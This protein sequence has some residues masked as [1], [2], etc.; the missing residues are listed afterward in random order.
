MLVWGGNYPMRVDVGRQI[1][2]TA[3][4]GTMLSPS[5]FSV[6]EK[7]QLAVDFA[8]LQMATVGKAEEVISAGFRYFS[9]SQT[10]GAFRSTCCV[11]I[12]PVCGRFGEDE[13]EC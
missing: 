4:Y 9:R 3:D 5:G 8:H 13:S 2:L 10:V 12:V 7:K 1:V 11:S 6:A